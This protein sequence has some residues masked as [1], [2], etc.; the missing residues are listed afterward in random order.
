MNKTFKKVVSI[1]LVLMMLFTIPLTSAVAADEAVDAGEENHQ[2]TFMFDVI[3]EFFQTIFG[4]FK[5]IFY[6]V[7]LGVPA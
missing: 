3:S 4:F 1:F 2:H 7:W 5:Y 6:D